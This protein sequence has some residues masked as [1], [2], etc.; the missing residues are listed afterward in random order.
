M[1]A[2]R[3]VFAAFSLTTALASAVAY[4]DTVASTPATGAAG[5]HRWGGHR[6]GLGAFHQVLKQLNLTP[7]QQ[8][9]IKAIFAQARAQWQASSASARS[10]HEALAATSPTDEA[11]PA[12]LATETANAA[13]RVQALSDI[14]TQIY[15]VLS[16]DQQA[17]IPGLL[18][19]AR[20]ARAA[21]IAAWRAQHTQS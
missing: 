13:A 8:T 11:Y 2:L 17:Q 12:L 6:H 1:S 21:R 5:Q 4:A 20:A 10:N 7:D 16:A 18:A 15:A 14:R 9:Q 19:S 3:H